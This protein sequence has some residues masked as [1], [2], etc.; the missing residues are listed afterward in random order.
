MERST[1][2]VQLPMRGNEEVV[3]TILH[4][5]LNVERWMLNVGRF[6]IAQF[7]FDGAAETCGTRP[8]RQAR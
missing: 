1:L 3:R 2:N 7:R 5:V 8:V 6:P 4:S